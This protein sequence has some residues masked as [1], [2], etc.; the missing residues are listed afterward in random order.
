MDVDLAVEKIA[1]DDTARLT[2][3]DD[4][5]EHLSARVHLHRAEADLTLECLVGSEKELLAGLSASVKRARDL[6]AAEGA[7]VE[8]ASVFAGERYA[9]SDALVDDV[10]AD[11]RET[12]D[13]GFAGTEIATLNGV[14]EEAVN[15][16]AIVVVILG[17]VDA[18]LRSDGMRAAWAVLKAEAVDVVTQ[19]T[20][21]CGGGTTGET[22]TNDDDVVLPLVGGIDELELELMLVP[23]L[24]DRPGGNIGF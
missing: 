21:A 1:G 23:G 10:Y 2:V 18:T 6:R 5:V 17:G 20:K 15:A 4:Q 24:L 11:L 12:V 14:V 8:Q 7:V 9:L 3:N 19:F 13:I 16:I 22:R